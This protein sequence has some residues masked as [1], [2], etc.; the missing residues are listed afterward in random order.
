MFQTELPYLNERL[1]QALS[2]R[3]TGEIND[4]STDFNSEKS[5][6]IDS[7]KSA[8]FSGEKS[9]NGKD[10]LESASESE[11]I[12]DIFSDPIKEKVISV[13]DSNDSLANIEDSENID[14]IDNSVDEMSLTSDGSADGLTE[15]NEE[16]LETQER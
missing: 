8:N 4:R 2:Q 15:N 7:E 16:D 13:S 1:A 9:S 12:S 6:K 10:N 14:T 3:I 5:T 11:L